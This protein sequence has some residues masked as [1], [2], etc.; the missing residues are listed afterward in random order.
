MTDEHPQ[1]QRPGSGRLWT[2][3]REE[4]EHTHWLAPRTAVQPPPDVESEPPAAEPPPRRLWP[5]VVL[6]ALL[7]CVLFATGILGAKLLLDDDASSGSLAALPAAPGGVAPDARSRA[8]REVYASASPSVVFV[9]SREGAGLASG[10][11]FVVGADGTIVTNAHVVGDAKDVQV[12]FEDNGPGVDA[13][14]LGTDASSDI[15]VLRV[16]PSDAGNAKPLPLA[17]S[18]SVQ[19]GDLAVAIGYPLGLDRTAT[20]GIV[21]GVGRDI[22]AP[23]GF[24]IDKVI[25][26][27]APINPGNSGGPLLDAAGRVIGITSQIATTGAGGGSVG[28]G[29]AVP[30]N[31]VRQVVPRLRSGTSIKRAYLGISTR[32]SIVGQGAQ[33][34]DVVVGGPAG[35]AGLRIGDRITR[36]AGREIRAPE[37]ISAAIANRRPGDGIGIELRRAGGDQ[38]VRVTLGTRPE[39]ASAPSA[40]GP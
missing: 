39:N 5:L 23:N 26:T 2:D 22:R 33:V 4:E 14:V 37:D 36:V 6:G 1:G 31:T 11:G 34:A 15:A 16:D 28:I 8:V 40:A 17:D 12:R 10:T 7:A 38:T 27:D 32:P 20:V 3:P 18:D 29:F 24:S 21:S 30:S 19:V 35:Q 13:E 9:R 25:Q